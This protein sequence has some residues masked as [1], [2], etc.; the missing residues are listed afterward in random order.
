MALAAIHP[1]PVFEFRR[2]SDHENHCL[3]ESRMA[4]AVA[5]PV[6]GLTRTLYPVM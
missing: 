5:F 3:F 1:A 6:Y 2:D 4:D